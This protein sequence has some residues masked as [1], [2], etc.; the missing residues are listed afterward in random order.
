MRV[1]P[2][3]YVI[4]RFAEGDDLR[5]DPYATTAADLIDALRAHVPPAPSD[6]RASS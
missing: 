3:G 6:P 5:L 4:V 2:M 1:S